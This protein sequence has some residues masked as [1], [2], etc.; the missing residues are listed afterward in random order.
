LRRRGRGHLHHTE[1]DEIADLL[2]LKIYYE[3]TDAAGVVYYGNYLR[4]L[5]RGRTEFLAAR[6]LHIADYH[7]RGVV[8]A[9]VHV[10]IHYRRPARLGDEIE[11]Q[12][13]LGEMGNAS[14]FFFQDV[15]RKG[16][17]IASA[18]VKI[19]C[20][21]GNGRPRRLPPELVNLKNI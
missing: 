16:E 13:G 18:R 17:L 2:K 6:G 19:A 11:V 8:F 9:V 3:D 7:N 12:T 20:L 15:V 1:G 21:D 5:E 14:V 4:Y 10:D